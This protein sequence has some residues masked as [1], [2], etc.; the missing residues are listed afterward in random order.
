[1]ALFA[2]FAHREPP[3]IVVSAGGL[4]AAA[5]LIGFSLSGTR[6][7]PPWLASPGRRVVSLALAGLAVGVI[8]GVLQR[9]RL[10]PLP[11]LAGGLHPFVALACLIGAT[12]ELVYRGWML[13]RLAALGWPAAVTFS[14]VAHGAYKTALFALPP[15]AHEGPFSLARIALWTV[16]GGLMLGWLRVRSQSVWPAVLAHAAFDAVVYS[17]FAAPPWW[18]WG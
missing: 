17:A 16:V 18:V 1:M 4:L 9:H 10:G 11:G 6:W 8:G 15:A 2:L 14:A 7:P 13:E 12:E 3:W 5:A